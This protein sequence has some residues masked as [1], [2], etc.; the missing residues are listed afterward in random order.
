MKPNS[1]EFK[2]SNISN[3]AKK[4]V[5]YGLEPVKTDLGVIIDRCSLNSQHRGP[6]GILLTLAV[7]FFLVNERRTNKSQRHQHGK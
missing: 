1:S 7:L 6:V 3:T 5:N 4:K 2:E